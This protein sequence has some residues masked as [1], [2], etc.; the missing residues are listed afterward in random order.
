MF[1]M[2]QKPAPVTLLSSDIRLPGLESLTLK[3][4][5]AWAYSDL[6]TNTVRPMYAEFL[7]T[8]ALGNTNTP[9]E[10]WSDV[11]VRSTAG[12]RVLTI[13]VKSSGYLQSWS[14]KEYSAIIFDI[15]KRQGW[16]PKTGTSDNT[17]VRS[18][19]CYVFCIYEERMDKTPELVLDVNRWSFY[20]VGTG[21]INRTFG[22]Q[23]Q[24]SLKA[25][26][27]LCPEPVRYG[28]IRVQIEKLTDESN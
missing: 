28:N 10:E 14:Q 22:D 16:D 23:K 9:R 17:P 24:V 5:W 8:A 6:L 12:E 13:E 11:D 21:D 26:Q 2:L 18:A 20:V 25:I 7:V 1:L 27:K 3:D 4:F 15:G 19:D